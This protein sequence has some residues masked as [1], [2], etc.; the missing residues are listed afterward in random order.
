MKLNATFLILFIS[1]IVNAQIANLSKFKTNKFED[2]LIIFKIKGKKYK[3]DFSKIF[4]TNDNKS[5]FENKT[6]DIIHFMI[7]DEKYLFVGYFPNTIKQQMSSVGYELRLLNR[8]EVIDLENSSKKWIYQFDNNITMNRIVNFNSKDGVIVYNN[9]IKSSDYDNR[10]NGS[11]TIC[12]IVNKKDSSTINFNICHKVNFDLKNTGQYIKNKEKFN[13]KWISDDEYLILNK[14]RL[15]D[16]YFSMHEKKYKYLFNA[17]NKELI[18]SDSEFVYFLRNS[19]LVNTSSKSK[20]EKV[21]FCDTEYKTYYNYDDFMV[22]NKIK[23]ISNLRK[24]D[25]ESLDFYLKNGVNMYEI[26]Q[27]QIIFVPK[28]QLFKNNNLEG[29]IP[30][31]ILGYVQNEFIKQYLVAELNVGQNSHLYM[32]NQKDDKIVS[33]FLVYSF[34]NSGF[35]SNYVETERLPKLVFRT[36]V[37]ITSDSIDK[38]SNSDNCIYIL[39]L[40]NN[41]YIELLDIDIMDSK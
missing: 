32:I 11:W 1:V 21:S 8:L 22:L 27:D 33:A 34:Y 7:Y 5:V 23:S 14:G 13:F 19:E 6:N 31:Y 9:T 16:K 39:Q 29:N 24:I 10:F 18:L 41:G 26:K 15:N 2:E 4:I 40:S 38:K 12:K 3:T 25:E 37:Y 28:S 35:G 36:K 30:I 20:W 17:N